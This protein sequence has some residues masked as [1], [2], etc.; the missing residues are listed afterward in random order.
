LVE[1]D[2]W[3]GQVVGRNDDFDSLYVVAPEASGTSWSGP[4]RATASDRRTYF[5]KSLQSCPPGQQASLAVEQIVAR[6]GDLVGAPVCWTSLIR[7]PAVLAGTV[8][9]PGFPPLQEGLAH[10]SLAIDH[11]DEAGRP[12]LMDRAKDG[13]CR[14]HVGVYALYDWC[15]GSDPQWLYDQ[16]NDRMTFSHDHGLYLPPHGMGGWTRQALID[17]VDQPNELPDA[18]AGL[19]VDAVEEVALALDSVTRTHLVGV[20][21]AVP[22]S[23]PVSN[24]NLEVLGWFLERRASAV[25]ARVKNLV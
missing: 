16:D 1:L 19:S 14:R 7:I 11:A 15:F 2:E 6:V 3:T 22:L 5:V 21:S 4:F 8:I 12:S 25:A 24:E 13:N 20:L 23:W 9:R 10:A 17:H 18:R